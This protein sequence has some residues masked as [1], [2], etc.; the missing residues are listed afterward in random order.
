MMSLPDVPGSP[1][2]S[3]IVPVFNCA[4]YIERLYECFAA[5]MFSDFEVVLVDD[6]SS[7]DSYNLICSRFGSESG[8]KSRII[9]QENRGVSSARNTG[10]RAARGKFVCFVDAD[11]VIADSYLVDLYSAVTGTGCGAAL[12]Y[13]TRCE[14]ELFNA[15]AEPE[16]FDK[17]SFL[18][19]FLYHGIKYSICCGMYRRALFVDNELYFYE[20]YRYSEDVHLLW[21][22]LALI[23]SVA[24][25]GEKLYYYFD[26]RDSAMNKKVDSRRMDA[27]VLMRELEP[28]MDIHAPEFSGEFAKYA[29]ARHYWSI[30]W[31]AAAGSSCFSDF[32][33]CM[34]EFGDV[35]ELRKLFGYPDVRVRVTSRLFVM[36][37][38]MYYFLIKFYV[39]L[40]K[41]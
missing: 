16:I 6:G 4:A 34:A 14:R 30:L 13:I 2:V 40:F 37:R 32:K 22:L 18:R 10:L 12:G 35:G 31:Q 29:V 17:V 24:V 3:V 36:S 27:I 7:D 39:K 33:A 23:P 1:A 28:F 41:R 8:F 9:R 21:R 20:G 15:D 11:D 26:N 38:R 19:E 25:V 5:Q